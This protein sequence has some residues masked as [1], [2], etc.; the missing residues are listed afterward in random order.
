M[1]LLNPR[2]PHAQATS[3][4]PRVAR[5]VGMSPGGALLVDV[6]HPAGPRLARVVEGLSQR[7]LDEAS[8]D[9]REVLVVF[10]DGDASRPIV[11]NVLQPAAPLLREVQVTLPEEAKLDASR[12]LLEGKDEIVL[13]CGAASITLRRNGRVIIRGVQIESHAAGLQ[14]IKGAAVKVN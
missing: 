1:S 12:V 5:L 7:T 8:R 6:G 9:G 2:N 4:A 10:E 13:S 3:A 11:L 14:R